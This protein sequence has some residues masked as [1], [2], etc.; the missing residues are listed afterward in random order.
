MG[1]L[2]CLV[3]KTEFSLGKKTLHVPEVFV[4]LGR[5]S[6]TQP[7][8]LNQRAVLERK[9]AE[10]TTNTACIIGVLD[11]SDGLTQL[12]SAPWARASAMRGKFCRAAERYSNAPG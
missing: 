3:C 7:L 1:T 6:L 8:V 12:T 11:S 9:T 10:L 5:S 2:G 4:L